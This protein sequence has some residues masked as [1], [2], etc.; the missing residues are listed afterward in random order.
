[1]GS[2]SPQETAQALA[3][4]LSAGDA[5]GVLSQ[6]EED[7]AFIPPGAPASNPVRGQA[8]LRDTMGQFLALNPTLTIETDKVIEVEEIALVTGSWSLTGSGP[9][10]DVN[11]SGR[12][13]DVMRRQSDGTWLY[14][15]DNP[16]GVEN[17]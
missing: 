11:M 5:D 7:A 6:Y 17:A 3:K 14:V 4:A 16:D 12:Y 9:D 2:N 13:V 15:I 10:G 1:M 8:A